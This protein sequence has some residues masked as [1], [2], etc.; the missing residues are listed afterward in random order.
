MFDGD[1]TR[2]IAPSYDRQRCAT[3]MAKDR[4]YRHEIH[5]LKIRLVNTGR[6]TNKEK[7]SSHQQ[8]LEQS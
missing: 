2:Y 7:E 1:L 6:R 3:R 8:H 5:I 4:P